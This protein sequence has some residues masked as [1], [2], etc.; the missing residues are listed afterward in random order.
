MVEPPTVNRMVAGSSP[1]LGAMKNLTNLQELGNILEEDFS[2]NDLSQEQLEWVRFRIAVLRSFNLQATIR[3]AE[4]IST[5][6]GI[7]V[8][9]M[10]PRD[11]WAMHNYPSDA[12][13]VMEELR[14]EFI[15]D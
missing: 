12:F 5:E 7:Q 15:K 11:S 9:S 6:L 3:L 13:R 10:N 8:E 2:K 4:Q 14:R 1:A